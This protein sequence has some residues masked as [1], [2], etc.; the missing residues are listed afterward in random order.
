MVSRRTASAGVRALCSGVLALACSAELGDQDTSG[1]STSGPAFGNANP[2]PAST[3]A[4]SSPP[5]MTSPSSGTEQGPAANA[6]LQMPQADAMAPAVEAP[7]TPDEQAALAK[8]DGLKKAQPWN[9]PVAPQITETLVQR[10]YLDWKSRFYKSCDDGTVYVLKDD[11]TGSKEVVS[12]GIGYGMLLSVA[13]GDRAVF[14]GLWKYYR[15]HRNGNGVMNWRQAVCGGQTGGN[16]ASDADLDSALG[17]VLADSRWGG[18]TDDAKNL[19]G[20]IGTNETQQCDN[21]QTILKP[22]DQFGGCGNGT[23]NPSYFSPG[24]YRLF[25][26]V[27]TDRSDFWTKLASDTYTML[28]GMQQA[29]DGLIPDWGFGDGRSEDGDRGQFGYE[30]VRNPW[31]VALDYGWSGNADAKSFLQR[32]SQ[33]VDAKGGIK[34]MADA[35]DFEDKRNSAFLGS[36]SLS[37]SAVDANKLDT[38]VAEWQAYD[39]LDDRWYYQA[40]LRVLFLMAAGGYFPASYK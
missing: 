7:L 10:A 4:Y 11:Y 18:Y 15:E 3:P 27:Q 36:L 23:V 40:T 2:P 29:K 30:A 12:E 34:A 17:L 21:G 9:A 37:G 19:I 6:A 5:A 22:G 39:D 28:K 13:I 25:A 31:R 26:A 24:H 8:F 1:S 20:A 38:Y 16:G 35:D 14:D 33:A 32:M